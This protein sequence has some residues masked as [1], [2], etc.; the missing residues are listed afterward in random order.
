MRKKRRNNTAKLERE[1][2]PTENTSIPKTEKRSPKA[3][4]GMK[5]ECESEKQ[6][7]KRTEK[8]NKIIRKNTSKRTR[9]QNSI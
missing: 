5:I 9:E 7:K 6:K 1:E 4:I 2:S 8:Q 3:K